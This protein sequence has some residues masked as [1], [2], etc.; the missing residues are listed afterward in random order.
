MKIAEKKK[1]AKQAEI[2]EIVRFQRVPP[3]LFS[4]YRENILKCQ[5]S[6]KDDFENN[7]AHKAN[8]AAKKEKSQFSC[9]TK[10]KA[11]AAKLE[12]P[13]TNQKHFRR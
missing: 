13:V 5:F 11:R 1:R 12:P 2:L 3:S 9:I 7:L 4:K 8:L 6:C 10:I